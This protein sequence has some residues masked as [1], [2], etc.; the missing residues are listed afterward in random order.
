MGS[1]AVITTVAEPTIAV[2]T[3]STVLERHEMQLVV[4]GDKKGPGSYELPC[5]VFLPLAAQLEM[6]FRLA[7]LLPIGHYARKNLGYLHA[8][9]NRACC[10]YE[11][12]DDNAP[13]KSWR[14]RSLGVK[15]GDCAKMGNLV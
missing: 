12:D 11:T 9:A 10:I 13:Q 3:L 6:P 8:I 14:P 2:R 4:V 1:H 15:Q 5:T 7:P